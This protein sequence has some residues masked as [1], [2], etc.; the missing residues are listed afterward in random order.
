MAGG[1]RRGSDREGG[2]RGTSPPVAHHGEARDAEHEGVGPADLEVEGAQPHDGGSAPP[3]PGGGGGPHGVPEVGEPAD[4]PAP[5]L[6]VLLEEV[7]A[8]AVAW[9]AAWWAAQAWRRLGDRRELAAEEVPNPPTSLGAAQPAERV[10]LV[11]AAAVPH[12]ARIAAPRRLGKGPGGARH[13][14]LRIAGGD[15]R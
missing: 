12:R 8:A 4:G 9:W 14:A 15:S 7:A 5:A 1:G 3:L 6:E 2:V 10:G 13:A 11:G